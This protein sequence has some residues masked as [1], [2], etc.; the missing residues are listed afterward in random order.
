[1]GI[2]NTVLADFETPSGQQYRIEL[3]EGGAIHIHTGHIR[4]DLNCDEFTQ[5]AD[6]VCNGYD[7]L[8]STKDEI[9]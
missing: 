4:I 2:V 6:A 3:N 8:K 9:Q 1:M 5:F 7:E